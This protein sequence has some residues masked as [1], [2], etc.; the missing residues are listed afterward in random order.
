M[1]NY[2][3]VLQTKPYQTHGYT[4]WEN[5]G[6]LLLK[7]TV[8]H[9]KDYSAKCWK[10][11]NYRTIYLGG[12]QLLVSSKR[13]TQ[14]LPFSTNWCHNELWALASRLKKFTLCTL[15]SAIHRA[16]WFQRKD[17]LILRNNDETSICVS[18]TTSESEAGLGFSRCYRSNAGSLASPQAHRRLV[19][20]SL[21][22]I[23]TTRLWR[24]Y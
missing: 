10:F 7:Q 1:R 18:W 24:Q 3:C 19:T 9:S 14:W 12:L 21:F 20:F 23:I 15:T 17:Q 5:A 4:L 16:P 6:I 11:L 13:T 2:H 8:R 22:L